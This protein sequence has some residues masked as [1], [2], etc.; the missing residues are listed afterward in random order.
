MRH[1]KVKRLS[2]SVAELW[3]SFALSCGTGFL[4]LKCVPPSHKDSF[5]HHGTKFNLMGT[6]HFGMCDELEIRSR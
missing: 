2:A 5:L 6:M 1:T 4:A 3:L